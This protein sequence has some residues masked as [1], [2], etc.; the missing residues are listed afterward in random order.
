MD[1]GAGPV[2]ESALDLRD[3]IANGALSISDL[4]EAC[5][6][7]IESR[8]PALHGVPVAIKD[9]I[10]TA[11]IP[12]ENG[13]SQ[14]KGR[15]PTEDA[16]LVTQLRSAGALILG[17]TVTTELAFMHPAGTRNPHD[18]GHTPGGS[19]SGSAAAVGDGMVPLAVGTQTGG[20]VIRPAAFCGVTGFKP[21]FGAI[22]RSGV[23]F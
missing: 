15:V 13:C 1:S 20:S 8:E 23:L 3:R 16:A 2:T 18:L 11:N 7:R 19:S 4:A 22:P 17:K 14:D 12:T 9:I 6:A 5:I 10:D 21:S